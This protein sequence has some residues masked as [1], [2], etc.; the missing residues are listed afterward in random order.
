MTPKTYKVNLTNPWKLL[1][2]LFSSVGLFF[3]VLFILV[4]FDLEVLGVTLA[5]ICSITYYF[6]LK[7]RIPQKTEI[8]ISNN[9]IVLVNR[10]IALSE[11][12]SYQIHRMRGAGLKLKMKDGKSIRLSSN[13]NFC[14][15]EGFVQFVNDFEKR[16]LEFPEISKVRSLAE[17]RLGLY[18]AIATTILFIVGLVYGMLFDKEFSYSRFGLML[19]ALSTLWSG[20]EIKKVFASKK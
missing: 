16:A 3:L 4:K 1:F 13:N 8:G 10:R 5:L 20:I 15:S 18:F 14:D 2:L 19:V 11:I 12:S 6:L 17:T 7:K 9:E